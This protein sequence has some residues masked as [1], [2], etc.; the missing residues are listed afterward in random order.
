MIIE[1]LFALSLATAPDET[2]EL[3]GARIG[4]GYTELRQQHPKMQCDASCS[5]RTAKVLGYPGNLWTGIGDGAINQLAFRFVPTLTEQEAQ[6]VSIAYRA[7]FGEPARRNAL[8]G[9]EEWDRPGGAI[10]LCVTGG[11]SLTYWKDENWGVTK[12]QIPDGT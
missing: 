3:A 7:R 2:F 12:S 1:A 11:L 8:D 4:L 6:G 5:D 10:V 9:C